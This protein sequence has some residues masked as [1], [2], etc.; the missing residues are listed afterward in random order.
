MGLAPHPGLLPRSQ[1]QRT[2]QLEADPVDP[3]AKGADPGLVPEQFQC[4]SL[5]VS[6]MRFDHGSIV[7]LGRCLPVCQTCVELCVWNAD[8]NEQSL[9]SLVIMLPATAIQTL[10]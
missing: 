6:G 7:A 3:K 2:R 10:H 4:T 9:Q 5:K 1:C 8:L